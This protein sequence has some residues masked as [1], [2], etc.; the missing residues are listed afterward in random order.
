[1][2]LDERSNVSTDEIASNPVDRRR[3]N[4]EGLGARQVLARKLDHHASIER[5][6]HG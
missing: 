2:P 5:L 4:A 3:V 6:S 1:M